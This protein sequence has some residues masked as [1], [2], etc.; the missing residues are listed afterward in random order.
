MVFLSVS[1]LFLYIVVFFL[2][3]CD[4]PTEACLTW[5]SSNHNKHTIS[6]PS[7]AIA[8]VSFFTRYFFN[9]LLSRVLSFLKIRSN[10]WC[11]QLQNGLKLRFFLQNSPENSKTWFW[12]QRPCVCY[13]VPLFVRTRRQGSSSS[14]Y[15]YTH[16]HIQ[17]LY[18]DTCEAKGLLS[19]PIFSF[20][21]QKERNSFPCSNFYCLVKKF[22]KKFYFFSHFF[23]FVKELKRVGKKK[24]RW[25]HPA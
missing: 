23:F 9:I 16:I 25:N 3:H 14:L 18:W 1:F 21:F 6:P 15:I 20:L 4:G 22:S 24:K 12:I 11:F 19:F 13:L 2:S 17:T 7:F 8:L 5:P 10:C